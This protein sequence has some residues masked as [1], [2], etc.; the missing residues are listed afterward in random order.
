MEVYESTE[1]IEDTLKDKY[2]TFSL[3]SELYGFTIEYVTEIISIRPITKVPELPDYVKGVINL[4]GKI[5]PVMDLRIRFKQPVPEYDQRTC[6][7]IVQVNDIEMG[8][9]AD[10][11]LEV[12]TILPDRLSDPPNTSKEG[13]NKYIWKLG[14][15]QSGVIMLL[16][17]EKL[18]W[19]EK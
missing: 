8:I 12:S 11:V 9:V 4:R 1:T 5:I 10:K 13:N 16:D 15:T 14:T 3:G 17:I 7:V 18:I 2:L 19:D 6:I